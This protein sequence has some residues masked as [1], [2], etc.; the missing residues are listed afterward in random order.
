M[1]M[2]LR[3]RKQNGEEFP[4]R[5]TLVSKYRAAGW[6]PTTTNTNININTTLVIRDITERKKAEENLRRS[7]SLIGL[8]PR[9][10]RTEPC[11][12]STIIYVFWWRTDRRYH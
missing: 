5:L 12:Y 6:F 1:M 2:E 9:I 3:A 4:N 11:I 7:E 10:S 8:L